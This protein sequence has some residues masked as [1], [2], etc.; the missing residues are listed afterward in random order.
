M[1][2]SQ[3]IFFI[4]YTLLLFD[5]DWSQLVIN[6][7]SGE[8]E[9]NVYRQK[10]TGNVTSDTVTVEFVT[11]SGQAVTQVTDFSSGVTVTRVTVPGELELGQDRYQ[12]VC[13]VSPGTG[14]MIQ[15]EAVSKLRQK[16]T[17]VTRVAEESRGRVV[18]D[19]SASLIVN[20]AQ[21]LSP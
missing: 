8:P 2:S 4:F 21:Y 7:S 12:V 13:F 19:N 9:A 16:H 14:D 15:P 18:V 10:V 11:A 6:V 3:N 1:R 17:G 5:G 20:K